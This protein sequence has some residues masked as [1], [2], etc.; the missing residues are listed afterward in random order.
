VTERVPSDHATVDSH[1]IHLETVGRTGRPRVP[2]PDAID[3]TTEEVL[4][5]SLEGVDAHAQVA[6]NLR[7]EPGLEGA[8]PDAQLARTGNGEN[9]LVEWVDRHGLG[10]GD[11]L[12]FDIVTAGY[13]YG[14]RR[15]GERV[16]YDAVQAPDDD[17][18]DIAEKLG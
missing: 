14:L 11:P 18:S 13:Q 8:Y 6:A 9:R 17:L 2:L 15:P 3:H 4:R 12:L 5:L 7:G 16:V 10:A 1:R